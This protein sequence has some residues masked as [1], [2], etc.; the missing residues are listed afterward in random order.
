M[1]TTLMDLAS[2][3]LLQVAQFVR[4]SKRGA[5]PAGPQLRQDLVKLFH[6][7][8][9]QA[10]ADRTLAETWQAARRPL[11]Y[12]VDETMIGTEWEHRGWWRDNSLERQLLGHAQM[13]RGILF[14]DELDKARK[15]CDQA[16]SGSRQAGH[17]LDL[18]TVFYCALRFGFRGKL[19][20]QP[21]EL[22]REAQDLLARLP[23]R[24]QP[25]SREFFGQAYQHT[26]E[27]PPTY[28]TYM[29]LAT[30]LG[31]A[32][33][34]VLLLVGFRKY[35]ARD[36]LDDLRRAADLAGSFFQSGA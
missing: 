6:E 29:R 36:L 3:V 32:A 2:R 31:L 35:L 12:L 15:S 24:V 10:G 19:S 34:L 28:E 17:L 25:D 11:V 20:G 22:E 33:A 5:A 26:V 1:A 8:D 13:M 9:Q 30:I 18:L 23:G 27:I 14:F 21:A 16:Q 7:L 4:Q